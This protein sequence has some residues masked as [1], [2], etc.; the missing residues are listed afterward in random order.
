MK[1]ENIFKSENKVK[2]LKVFVKKDEAVSAEQNLV[3]LKQIK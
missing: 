2:V 3:K 1:M